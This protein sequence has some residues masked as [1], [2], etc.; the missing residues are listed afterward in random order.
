MSRI[1]K[2][3]DS[4]TNRNLKENN[5]CCQTGKEA[6]SLPKAPSPTSNKALHSSG[7]LFFSSHLQ[8]STKHQDYAAQRGGNAKDPHHEHKRSKEC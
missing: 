8:G 3:L 5:G 1:I 7:I 6:N 4:L 2:S